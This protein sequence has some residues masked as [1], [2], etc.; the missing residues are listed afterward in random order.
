MLHVD[1][2]IAVTMVAKR[3]NGLNNFRQ[4][5]PPPF[6][7]KETPC[8]STE[9]V[10]RASHMLHSRNTQCTTS[11]ERKLNGTTVGSN[12]N[13]YK[14]CGV[15]LN[16]RFTRSLWWSSTNCTLQFICCSKLQRKK[17][18]LCSLTT[19]FLASQACFFTMKVSVSST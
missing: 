4:L 13:D 18:R 15:K 10:C 11:Q 12:E 3:L 8:K 5:V 16:D 1:C 6:T 19:S 17:N 7:G 2:D 14:M 9:D